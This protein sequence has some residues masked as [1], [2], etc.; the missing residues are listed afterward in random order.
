MQENI[1]VKRRLPEYDLLK[2]LGIF[3]VVLG[4]IVHVNQVHN[5]IYAFHMPLFFVVSGMLYKDKPDF[6]IKQARRTLVPYFFFSFLCFAYWTLVEIRYRGG[7]GV[8]MLGQ[9]VNIFY[10]IKT[11]EFNVVLWFIPCLF[12]VSVAYNMLDRYIKDR[13]IIWIVLIAVMFFDQYCL[14]YNMPRFFKQVVIAIP[15]YG[16]GVALNEFVDVFN[17]IK[18]RAKI[19]A[20]IIFVFFTFLFVWYVDARNSMMVSKFENGYLA[21]FVI[22]IVCFGCFYFLCKTLIRNNSVLE[23]LGVN[24]LLIM[25]VHEP[26]KRVL[27]HIYSILTHQPSE[28]VRTSLTQSLLLTFVLL[29]VLVPVVM[30]FDRFLKKIHVYK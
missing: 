18:S 2:G 12:L 11:F 3:L 21:F 1:K 20:A 28:I 23:W 30:F 13:R 24:S 5:F 25:L 22:A 6:I 26:V 7:G 15:F 14:S 29:I 9:L 4:H 17:S 8:D 10:P 19:S 16:F 27:I